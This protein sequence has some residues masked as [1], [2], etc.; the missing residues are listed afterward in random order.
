MQL[1]E[2]HRVH[3]VAGRDALDNIED[4]WVTVGCGLVTIQVAGQ[5][6][7]RIALD[8]S[9]SGNRSEVPSEIVAAEVVIAAEGAQKLGHRIVGGLPAVVDVFS[10]VLV[11]VPVSD[12]GA[13][14]KDAIVGTDVVKGG[15]GTGSGEVHL[16][17]FSGGNSDVL[18]GPIGSHLKRRIGSIAIVAKVGDVGIGL[19]R[20]VVAAA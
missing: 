19:R 9:E 3:E 12:L 15:I 14:L 4:V 11:F 20:R 1:A 10:G 17:G 13:K 16:R 18:E 5:I 7:K 2:I 8:L 6:G